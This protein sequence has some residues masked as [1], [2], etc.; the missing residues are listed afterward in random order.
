[1]KQPDGSS[2]YE[3]DEEDEDEEEEEVA[4]SQNLTQNSFVENK[5]SY[6]YY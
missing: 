3:D 2:E 4:E 6:C 1:M 5:E